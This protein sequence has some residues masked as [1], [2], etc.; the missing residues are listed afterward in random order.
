MIPDESSP[1]AQAERSLGVWA[2]IM[3]VAPEEYPP[4]KPASNRNPTNCQIFVAHPINAIVTAI[5]RL[6]LRSIGL[7]P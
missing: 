3:I 2:A 4:A 1:S 7:R 5:P 6:A